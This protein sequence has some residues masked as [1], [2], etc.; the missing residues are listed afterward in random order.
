M[1]HLSPDFCANCI[2]S[3]CII[4]LT[5]KQTNKKNIDENIT[6][7]AEVKHTKN[8]ICLANLFFNCELQLDQIPKHSQTE[9]FILHANDQPIMST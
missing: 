9:T 3:F 2:S 1:R 5:R 4:L 6:F 7:L 8:G